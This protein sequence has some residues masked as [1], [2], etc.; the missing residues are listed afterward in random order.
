LG[1]AAGVFGEELIDEDIDGG[2]EE[3]IADA[4]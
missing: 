4:M 2:K 3:R 1:A